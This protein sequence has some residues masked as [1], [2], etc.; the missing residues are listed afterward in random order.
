MHPM[1]RVHRLQIGDC[2]DEM[3]IAASRRSSRQARTS[4]RHT[5]LACTAVVRLLLAA[6]A[7]R[8]QGALYTVQG[9]PSA[10]L[11]VLREH[12]RR[13]PSIATALRSKSRRNNVRS[14]GIAKD[15]NCICLF[16]LPHQ[17]LRF[18]EDSSSERYRYTDTNWLEH[19]LFVACHCKRAIRILISTIFGT[20]LQPVAFPIPS[21]AVAL[22]AVP[23]GS[24]HHV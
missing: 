16:L 11:A 22:S 23:S 8:T 9:A 14:Y 10:A 7:A 20:L 17:T 21:S 5:T 4:W 2:A 3:R 24:S 19:A 15:S 12:R 6:R 1:A 13:R 18:A